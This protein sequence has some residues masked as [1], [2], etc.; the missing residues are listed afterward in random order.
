MKK[1]I[2]SLIAIV[3]L[4]GHAYSV[5]NL[6][7]DVLQ[8]ISPKNILPKA[9]DLENCKKK[10]KPFL[11]VPDQ[12][13]VITPGHCEL[14]YINGATVLYAYYASSFSVTVLSG[15]DMGVQ[16]FYDYHGFLIAGTNAW[17]WSSLRGRLVMLHEYYDSEVY[18]D[19][20]GQ[21]V[22]FF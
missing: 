19:Y 1:I 10:L 14:V 13:V 15:F 11:K 16:G 12:S 3:C 17:S 22:H 20:A 7:K 8:E 5:E 21:V 9:A 18:T 2:L 6:L 4:F